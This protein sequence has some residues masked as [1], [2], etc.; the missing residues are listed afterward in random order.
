MLK[1]IVSIV[2]LGSVCATSL[3]ATAPGT[4]ATPSLDEVYSQVLD[5]K[6]RVLK[7]E[8][9]NRALKAQMAAMATHRHSMGFRTGG[10]GGSMSLRLLKFYLEHNTCMDCEWMYRVG[11]QHSSERFT[12]P[13]KL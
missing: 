5:L 8:A 13:P 2:L 9:D 1:S 11:P 7:L 3:A 6:S 4:I 12:G 10:D